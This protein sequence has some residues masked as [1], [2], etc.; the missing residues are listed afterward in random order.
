MTDATSSQ[1]YLGENPG[2]V[3]LPRVVE[4]AGLWLLATLGGTSL[5][6][7]LVFAVAT[8]SSAEAERLA[9]KGSGYTAT[10]VS[11]LAVAHARRL[12]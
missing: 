9:G 4:R 5:A 3:P 6:A 12:P 1:L 2:T 8:Q 7:I 11:A 10:L